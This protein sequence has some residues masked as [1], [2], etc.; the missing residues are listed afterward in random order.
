MS[1]ERC[2]EIVDKVSSLNKVISERNKENYSK[3]LDG[4]DLLNGTLI[5]LMDSHMHGESD[6]IAMGMINATA[7]AK[8]DFFYVIYIADK[9]I[10]VRTFHSLKVAIEWAEIIYL[11]ET[12]NLLILRGKKINFSA[13]IPVSSKIKLGQPI[14]VE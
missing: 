12:E 4:I 9:K 7:K 2:L 11:T 5:D 13:S 1:I 10:Q 3:L 14:E 6:L 8:G